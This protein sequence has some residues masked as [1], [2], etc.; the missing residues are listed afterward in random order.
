[1]LPYFDRYPRSDVIA[2]PHLLWDWSPDLI[3]QILAE[4]LTPR[5]AKVTLVSTAF[6]AQ[7]TGEGQKEDGHDS[8]VAKEN[9][10]S[11]GSDDGSGSDVSSNE[12]ADEDSV[13][14]SESGSEDGSEEEEDEEEESNEPAVA[15]LSA[16]KI[17]SLYEGPAE[18]LPLVLPPSQER[19]CLVE[20]HFGTQY[21]E[22]GIPESLYTLWEGKNESFAALHLPPPNPFIPSDL[23]LIT[24]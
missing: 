13:S 4:Q 19:V 1:M 20:P 14:G 7:Q 12:G 3:A 11:A 21:W 17:A 23:S 16:E 8:A 6:T 10:E 22:D 2:A 5:R 18:W 15:H 9:D 24:V